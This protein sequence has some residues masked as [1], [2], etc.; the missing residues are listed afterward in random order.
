MIWCYTTVIIKNGGIIMGRLTVDIADGLLKN[1]EEVL[2]ETGL[3][4]E[5]AVKVMLKRV[6]REGNISFLFSGVSLNT[7]DNNAFYGGTA[8]EIKASEPIKMT[9]NKAIALFKSNGVRINGNVTFASKN[10]T[11]H[12]YWANPSFEVL[13]T[14]WFLILNDWLR[15]KL[16]LFKIPAKTYRYN[17]LVSRADKSQIDLQIMYEDASF[18]DSRSKIS[19]AEYLKE[20][21]SY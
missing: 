9:K 8:P 1:T 18:T 12:N 7:L 2:E 16:Y 21:V 14:D 6:A 11:A 13:D 3:D 4:I 10:K 15:R 20:T 17:Q 19:F 5:T